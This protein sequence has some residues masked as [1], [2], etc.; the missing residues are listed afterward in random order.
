MSSNSKEDEP[1][2]TQQGSASPP[3]E[4]STGPE[5]ALFNFYVDCFDTPETPS[6]SNFHELAKAVAVFLKRSSWALYGDN[7]DSITMNFHDKRPI[8]CGTIP[9]SELET[10]L[11]KAYPNWRETFNVER[12]P[13]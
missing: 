12:S 7:A 6:S 9:F 3:Q 4:E 2:P 10:A 8:H 11:S 1:S 5:Q 13:N